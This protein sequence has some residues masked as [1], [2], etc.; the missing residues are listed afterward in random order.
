[1]EVL[2][3]HRFF[4]LTLLVMLA[5]SSFPATAYASRTQITFQSWYS[6]YEQNM[7]GSTVSDS[8]VMFGPS[9]RVHF[10]KIYLGATYMT[11]TSD[12]TFDLGGG[13]S[14][15]GSKKDLDLEVGYYL[16][17][18]AALHAGWKRNVLELEYVSGGTGSGEVTTT[19]PSFGVTG[20]APLGDSGVSVVGDFTIMYLETTTELEGYQDETVDQTGYSMKAG[21]SYEFLR[22]ATINAGYTHQV[23]VPEE[24]DDTVYTGAYLTL[25]YGV[26]LW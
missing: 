14:V 12:Y 3:M 11:T 15:A 9:A 2:A 7:G 17:D 19:G 24:G 1:M 18:L 23:Y 10:K 8:S 6:R 21:I 5:M 22:N 16:G 4:A 20:H 25:G 26:G 13:V